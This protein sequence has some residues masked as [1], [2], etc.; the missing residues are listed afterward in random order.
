MT[1]RCPPSLTPFGTV[2]LVVMAAGIASFGV[3]CFVWARKA[4]Y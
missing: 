4:R 3:F 1:L 2:L